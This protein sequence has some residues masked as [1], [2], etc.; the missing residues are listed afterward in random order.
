MALNSTKTI[1]RDVTVNYAKVY[2]PET[3]QFGN[4]EF[5]IQ[6]EFDKSRVKEMA[7]FGNP[8]PLPNGNLAIN[9]SR[10]EKNKKGEVAKIRVVD[11]HKQPFDKPIGNGSTASLL[12]STY[13]APMA[14]TL[15]NPGRKTILFAVQIINHV[16]YTPESDVD[17]DVVELT[18]S[19]SEAQSDF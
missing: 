7:M 8:R 16:E 4:T 11:I 2:K 13:D 14:K 10:S 6:L 5:D 19:T 1:I 15:A 18:F 3:N 9:I 17:F 12:V